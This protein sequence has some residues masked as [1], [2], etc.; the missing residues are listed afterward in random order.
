MKKRIRAVLVAVAL[1]GLF[2]I[3]LH[4]Q[5]LLTPYSSGVNPA[6]PG[7]KPRPVLISRPGAENPARVG[8]RSPGDG[9]EAFLATGSGQEVPG[10]KL[11]RFPSL[12]AMKKF[13]ALAPAG[14]LLGQI[15]PLL[16]ARVRTGSWLAPALAQTGGT[17]SGNFYVRIPEVPLEVRERGD[18]MYQAVGKKALDLMGAPNV[19]EAWGRGVKVALMDT[20]LEGSGKMEGESSGHGT[21]MQSLIRGNTGAAR[22]AA[23][24]VDL[25]SFPVLDQ[26]GKGDSFR[27]AA[28]LVEAVNQGAQVINLS[29][30]S[31]GDSPVVRD[32]VAYALARNVGLVAAAGN[33]AVNRVSFPAAYEGVLAVASVDAGNNHLYFSNR[34]SAVD[35]AAPGFAVVAAWPGGKNVE[36]TGTS[37]STALVSGAVAALVSKEP[38]LTGLQAARLLA[39]YADD[40][41]SPGRDDETGGGLVNLQ[42]VM[43]RNQR[44]IVDVAIAGVNLKE[45]GNL[46]RISAAIQNR[47]TETVNSPVLEIIAGNSRRKFYFGSLAPGQTVAESMTFDLTRA[48]ED[49]GI[50]AGAVVSV[51]GDQRN[52]NDLWSGYFRISS[53]P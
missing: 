45:E 19:T 43:E 5:T 14:A 49:G 8:G 48:R 15:D 33:E 30:G 4:P 22:G 6:D 52:E 23:P 9:G 11:V 32:A 12:D 10:E 37:A 2:W 46:G 3:M 36:M 47:G 26:E 38:G 28:A 13:F 35:V 41:G 21:A 42:R 1:F 31:E 7:S 50:A 18:T 16:A 27:L 40:V 24:G 20:P 53:N 34:G 29:L 17:L 51:R 39:S 44:G 25:V